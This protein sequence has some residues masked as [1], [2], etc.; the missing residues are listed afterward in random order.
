MVIIN[1]KKW[2]GDI[3][4]RR[5]RKKSS[6]ETHRQF[7]VDTALPLEKAQRNGFN[8]IAKGYKMTLKKVA[9]AIKAAT[10]KA[11]QAKYHKVSINAYI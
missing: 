11:N 1:Y 8:T 10:R 4:L 2:V 3:I 5:R 9:H 6:L 7:I